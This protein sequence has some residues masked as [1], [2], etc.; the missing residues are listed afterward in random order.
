MKTLYYFTSPTCGPCKMFRPI[1]ENTVSELNFPT[2][3]IDVS[4]SMDMANKFEVRA[5]PT[6]MIIEN[7]QV[8]KRHTGIMNKDQFKQFISN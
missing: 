5:V 2:N 6:S 8:L 1:V 4:V 3:Y 7:G